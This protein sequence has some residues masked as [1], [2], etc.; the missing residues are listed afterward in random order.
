MVISGTITQAGPASAPS[1][2]YQVVYQDI[3]ITDQHGGVWPGRIGSK[4][5]YQPNTP[6]SF[7]VERK[8]GDNGPY[9]YFR[10]YNPQYPDRQ[11][12]PQQ[13]S[14]GPPQQAQQPNSKKDVD[15]DAK[16][17]RMARECALKS[18]TSLVCTLAE[19]TQ[20]SIG[21]DAPRI[22]GVAELF[23][24]YIYNGNRAIPDPDSSIQEPQYSPA[25]GP[26]DPENLPQNRRDDIPI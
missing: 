21:L 4:Q 1:G 22:K 26:W 12:P 20:K 23:V 11:A 19:L 13:A 15:W 2:Q 9:N 7:T 16:D 3:V 14:Q 24:D 6:I 8:Q 17:L 18:A 5:G 25:E 10:K